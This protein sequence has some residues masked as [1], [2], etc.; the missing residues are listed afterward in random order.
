M[1]PTPL[2]LRLRSRPSEIPDRQDVFVVAAGRV[3]DPG[4]HPERV[5]DPGMGT[6]SREPG[7]FWSVGH[8]EGPL[9]RGAG[10]GGDRGRPAGVGVALLQAEIAELR[11]AP[12]L[13]ERTDSL[14]QLLPG[15]YFYRRPPVVVHAGGHSGFTTAEL[16]MCRA[17]TIPSAVSERPF[18]PP[19]LRR[20]SPAPR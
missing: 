5:N 20:R 14:S 18:G 8:R 19:T 6:P 7:D 17:R 13:A 2:I 10:A 3:V 9:R 11:Q 16:M 1:V 12:D 15:R 4:G